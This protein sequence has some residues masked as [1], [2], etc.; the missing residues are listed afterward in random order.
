MVVTALRVLSYLFAGDPLPTSLAISMHMPMV[1]SA[2]DPLP[3]SIPMSMPGFEGDPESVPQSMPMPTPKF[4]PEF[5]P[6]SAS[7]PVRGVPVAAKVAVSAPVFALVSAPNFVPVLVFV[8]D[9]GGLF[10]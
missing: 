2:G 8:T 7:V 5:L 9:P 1:G 3:T 6:E 4:L 10:S